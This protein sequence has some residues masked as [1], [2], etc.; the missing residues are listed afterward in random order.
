MGNVHFEIPAAAVLGPLLAVF[1]LVVGVRAARRRAGWTGARAVTRLAAAGYAAGV[2]SVTVLPVVVTWGE[3]ANLMPWHSQ[4]DLIPLLYADFRGFSLN[5][6]MLVPFGLLV[7]LMSAR[8]S[9][10]A[11]VA[12]LSAAVSLSIEI[13]Q[14]LAY[15]LYNQAR[16]VEVNDLIA[17]TLGGMV[18]YLAFLLLSRVPAS[19]GVLRA[20]ALPGSAAASHGVRHGGDSSAARPS[21]AGLGTGR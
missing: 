8:G 18:G 16:T 9:S 15:L 14:L 10:L 7:P 4:V 3:Y 5:V 17:N 21:D 2:L 12:A 6:L 11:R 1:G 19:A 20:F 13:A